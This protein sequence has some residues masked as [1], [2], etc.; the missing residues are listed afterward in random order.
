ME[1]ENKV[2]T[3]KGL[4]TT[5]E[6]IGIGSSESEVAPAENRKEEISEQERVANISSRTEN[7]CHC[8][9]MGLGP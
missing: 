3:N 5:I 9:E 7:I 2:V 6:T 8:I 4:N 1:I